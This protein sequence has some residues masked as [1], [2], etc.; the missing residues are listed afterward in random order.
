MNLIHQVGPGD[1]KI[2][3]TNEMR[4][5]VPGSI[6]LDPST[7]MVLNGVDRSHLG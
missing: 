6:E 5:V 7:Q 2:T 4:T 1:M 3:E